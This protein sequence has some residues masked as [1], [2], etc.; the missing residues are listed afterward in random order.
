VRRAIHF[1]TH[2][3]H[4][5]SFVIHF[6]THLTHFW[7]FE[8]CYVFMKVRISP[9]IHLFGIKETQFLSWG[10]KQ[11]RI[12]MRKLHVRLALMLTV[13]FECLKTEFCRRS[14]WSGWKTG[15]FNSRV[16]LPLFILRP[17]WQDYFTPCGRFGRLLVASLQITNVL[18]I[19]KY[20]PPFLF[21]L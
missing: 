19:K 3:T 4:F 15:T 18:L 14:T 20:P 13:T 5:R 6:L 9:R 2:L 8:D 12:L 1:L 7:P 11:T 21:L 10:L 17:A 16:L